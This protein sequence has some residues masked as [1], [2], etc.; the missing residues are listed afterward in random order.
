MGDCK[1]CGKPAGFLRDKHAACVSLREAAMSD[2]P[3]MV[4]DACESTDALDGLHDRVR[5]KARQSFISEAETRS[6]MARGWSASVNKCLDDG[7]ISEDEE[8][9]LL[10]LQASLSLSQADLDQAGAFSKVVKAAVIRDL[11]SGTLPKRVTLHG[12]L[13]IN[14]QKG[15]QIVWAF[16]DSTLLEDKIRRSYVGGS[17]GVSIRIMQGVYYR[18]GAYRGNAVDRTER[19]LVDSGLTVVTNKHVY[20]AGT[21]KSFRIPFSKM[22][23]FHPFSDGIGIVRDAVNAKTQIIVTGDGWFTHNIVANLARM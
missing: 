9:R 19:V 11:L 3:S 8:K 16:T 1:V 15:E 10:A 17:Q 6:L 14:M 4:A 23:A 20:F 5:S 12:P 22:V 21:R 13:P 2:I 7:V 18:V